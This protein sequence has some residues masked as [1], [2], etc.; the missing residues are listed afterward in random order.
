MITAGGAQANPCR[1]TAVVA[2]IG[3]GTDPLPHVHGD[4][5]LGADGHG[6]LSGREK[7]TLQEATRRQ[8]QR[9]REIYRA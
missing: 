9:E 3:Q 5:D 7:K 6:S 1:A 4:R 8:Q 2:G